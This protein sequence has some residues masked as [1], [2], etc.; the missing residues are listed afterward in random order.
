M[1]RIGLLGFIILLAVAS[2]T[3]K[4]QTNSKPLNIFPEEIVIIYSGSSTCPECNNEKLPDVLN[5]LITNFRSLGDSLN[6]GIR[7]IGVSND[8]AVQPGYKHLNNVANFDEIAVGNGYLN[9][10]LNKYFIQNSKSNLSTATPQILVLK[11]TYKN[12]DGSSKSIDVF[13]ISNEVEIQR[14]YGLKSIEFLSSFAKKI[15]F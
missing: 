8:V 9:T 11:R 4:P 1:S 12:A 15:E 7:F 14:V 2:C 13:E 3:E 5:E 6:Y 10:V